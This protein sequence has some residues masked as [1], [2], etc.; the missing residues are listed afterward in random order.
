M[1]LKLRGKRKEKIVQVLK[2]ARERTVMLSRKECVRAKTP[3][4][5]IEWDVYEKR[6]KGE[7][8][9]KVKRDHVLLAGKG[10]TLCAMIPKNE[11]GEHD[12]DYEASTELE[13]REQLDTSTQGL[14]AN[15]Q[16]HVFNAM[17]SSISKAATKANESGEV[18]QDPIAL[19][20]SASG[21]AKGAC[22]PAGSSAGRAAGEEESLSESEDE[23][24]NAKEFGS[25]DPASCSVLAGLLGM[26]APASSSGLTPHPT[27][28]RT[29]A[30]GKAT[31]A[32]AQAASAKKAQTSPAKRACG[33]DC[34]ADEPA[35][36]GRKGKGKGANIPVEP[37]ALLEY[38]GFGDVLKSISSDIAKL[39]QAPLNSWDDTPI[40]DFASTCR[41]IV[42]R[43]QAHI[44][45]IAVI[46]ARI[47]KRKHSPPAA[48]DEIREV[49]KCVKSAITLLLELPKRD[50]NFMKCYEC[51]MDM[52][53]GGYEIG[54]ALIKK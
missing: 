26:A 24:V 11:E 31:S 4:R 43:L 9:S 22:A 28:N 50:P 1:P 42:T 21:A 46:D 17:Q 45:S 30:K 39:T 40:K 18:W 3:H 37:K 49:R 7:D 38:E 41:S 52:A 44:S 20:L 23:A 5:A 19:A 14:R 8:L 13:L 53:K 36:A 33:A 54:A 2:D 10:L 32:T 27:T 35:R 15:Q 6:H 29:P 47:S 25:F 16:E 48:L 34:E 12:V 51:Y